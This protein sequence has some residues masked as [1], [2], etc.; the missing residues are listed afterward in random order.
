MA[1]SPSGLNVYPAAIWAPWR[2]RDAAG[3]PA[4]YA[5]ANRPIAGVLHRMQGHLQYA[6]DCAARGQADRSWHYT[7]ALDG[8]VFAHLGHEHGAYHAGIT[9]DLARAYPPPWPLWWGPGLNVNLYTVGIECE[10]F[11]GQPW[12]EPQ[13]RAL[14]SLVHWLGGALRAPLDELHFP[15]HAAINVRDRAND[16]DYP[17]NR[18]AI[19][20]YL[21]GGKDEMTDDERALLLGV[22]TVL[23]GNP[24]GADYASVSE[25]LAAIRP[26]LKEDILIRL[27]LGRTQA[28]VDALRAEVATQRQALAGHAT[29][30]NHPAAGETVPPHPHRVTIE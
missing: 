28:D 20:R 27:G 25:A 16:F 10:G 7:V 24:T 22:A 5:N 13:L 14:R 8:R 30:A 29:P 18:P 26:L 21:F 1:D 11:S 6:L 2:A 23:A 3:A 4:Y 19:Y 17:A 12:P 15:P 9:D